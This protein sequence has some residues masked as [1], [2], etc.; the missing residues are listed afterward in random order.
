M[1]NIRRLFFYEYICVDL[2]NFIKIFKNTKFFVC[3]VLT[4]VVK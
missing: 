1:E 4:N 2:F 3:D